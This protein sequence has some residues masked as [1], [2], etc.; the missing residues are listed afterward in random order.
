LR[1]VDLAQVQHVPLHHAPPGDPRILDNAPVAVLLAILPANAALA[2][3][4]FI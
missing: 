4:G 1:V 2:G 3:R